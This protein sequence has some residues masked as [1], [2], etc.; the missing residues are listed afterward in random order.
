[1]HV[2]L[3]QSIRI[4]ELHKLVSPESRDPETAPITDMPSQ[5][6]A[7]ITKHVQLVRQPTQKCAACL[8]SWMSRAASQ[9]RQHAT[10]VL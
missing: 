8:L 5:Q 3:E 10:T 4:D 7:C 2:R 9:I 1:M 6:T